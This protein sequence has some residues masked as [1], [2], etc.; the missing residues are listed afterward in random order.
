MPRQHYPST[1]LLFSL[2]CAARFSANQRRASFVPTIRDLPLLPTV[3]NLNFFIDFVWQ[4][5]IKILTWYYALLINPIVKHII[6]ALFANI[7]SDLLEGLVLWGG[8]AGAVLWGRWQSWLQCWLRGTF[9]GPAPSRPAP[10]SDPR[11]A[12]APRPVYFFLPRV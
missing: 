4:N 12:T 3:R 2:L 8:E 7:T 9:S 10:R 11:P 6:Y 1:A 5:V